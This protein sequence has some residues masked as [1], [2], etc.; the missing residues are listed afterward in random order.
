M[1]LTKENIGKI[2]YKTKAVPLAKANAEINVALL[3]ASLLS[4]SR[5]RRKEAENKLEKIKNDKPETT[6][7]DVLNDM[8]DN[9]ELGFK[10]IKFGVVDD[11]GES[12]FETQE[13]FNEL[14]LAI[15]SE[16]QEAIFD[17]NGLSEKSQGELEKN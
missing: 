4:E 2:K 9:E 3:P 13:S 1:L 12:V 6:L 14:P 17:Y 15:Q 10:I 7:E 5:E 8:P 11:K 16:I